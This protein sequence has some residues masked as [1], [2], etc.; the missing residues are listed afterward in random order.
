MII[1]FKLFEQ[2]YSDIDPLGK[3]DW[4]IDN[5]TPLLQI[6]RKKYPNKNYDKI[7][8][9][10]CSNNRLNNLYGIEN[11]VNLKYLFCSNNQLTTLD[12]IENLINLRAIMCSNNNFSNEYKEY[13]K[14]Y[15][16]KNKIN[17]YQ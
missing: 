8:A 3:E 4:E 7:N 10:S 11:L 15:C 12:D 13:I 14:D 1:K 2:I 5:L 17:L 6:V 16:L 9:L